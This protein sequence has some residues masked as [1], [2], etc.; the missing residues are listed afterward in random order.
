LGHLAPADPVAAFLLGERASA[1]ATLAEFRDV[2]ITEPRVLTAVRKVLDAFVRVG[3]PAAVARVEHLEDPRPEQ[4]STARMVSVQ[5]RVLGVVAGAQPAA[6]PRPMAHRVALHPPVIVG[7]VTTAPCESGIDPVD[8]ED[9]G[10]RV[11]FIGRPP[12]GA[13]PSTPE[14]GEIVVSA[15][16]GCSPTDG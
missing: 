11:G 2:V 4:L 3:W 14:S 6:V 5:R 16:W 1:P 12:E 15:R 9:A 7:P 13:T 10:T 8:D